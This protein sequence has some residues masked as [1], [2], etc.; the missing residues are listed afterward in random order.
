MFFL[1]KL[2]CLQVEL[3]LCASAAF[4][5]CTNACLGLVFSPVSGEWIEQFGHKHVR[6][7]AGISSVFGDSSAGLDSLRW[8]C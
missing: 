4:L 8:L 3:Q 2:A 5:S 6:R 7:A 1:Y